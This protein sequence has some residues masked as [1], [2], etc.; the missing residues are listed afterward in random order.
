MTERRANELRREIAQT[1]ATGDVTDPWIQRELRRAERRL[2][3]IERH[4]ARENRA[5]A[6]TFTRAGGRS[7]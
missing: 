7:L 4:E 5:R 3:A 6:R 2:A 1:L